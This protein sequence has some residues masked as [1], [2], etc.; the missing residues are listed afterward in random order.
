[1]I[2]PKIFI[3]SAYCDHLLVGYSI[4]ALQTNGFNLLRCEVFNKHRS[5][6]HGAALIRAVKA[7]LR[8][9][10]R[11]KVFLRVNYDD[12]RA[13]LFLKKFDFVAFPERSRIYFEYSV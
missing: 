7:R 4:F 8:V 13:Q 12:L 9:Q 6:G 10:S 3:H 11:R 5:N 1:V 2:T